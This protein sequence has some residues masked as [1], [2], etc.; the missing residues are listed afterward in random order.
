MVKVAFQKLQVQGSNLLC[1]FFAC[2]I[3]K[4]GGTIPVV[5][6]H[7]TK[8]RSRPVEQ[9][10][11]AGWVGPFPSKLT[12]ATERNVHRVLT[13]GV[14][15]SL[16]SPFAAWALSTTVVRVT[17]RDFIRCAVLAR[18]AGYDGVEIMGRE[19]YLG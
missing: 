16:V 12:T 6:T 19:G 7:V 5:H 10:D 8:K 4:E 18:N 9:L 14:T 17:A 3:I 13:D 1:V 11:R 15:H 2:C